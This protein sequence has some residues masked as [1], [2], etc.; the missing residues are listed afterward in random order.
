MKK[1]AILL[2][3]LLLC[4][5]AAVGWGLLHTSLQVIGK[6]VQVTPAWQRAEEFETLRKAV[7][8]QSLLGT[9][10]RSGELGDS[11][12]YE[13]YIYT[14]RL[15]NPGLVRAEMVEMQISPLDCDVLFY[16]DTEELQ[17]APFETRDIRCVLLTQGSAHPVRDL[18]VTYYLWGHP[19]EVKYTYAESAN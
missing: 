17:I 5:S 18:H 14:L 9:T 15:R 6:G 11:G 16:G 4:A 7:R 12:E 10:L 13:F 8:E 1:A 2:F 19:Y 3:L